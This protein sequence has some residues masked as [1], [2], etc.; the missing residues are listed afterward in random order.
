MPCR[1][2]PPGLE[3]RRRFLHCHLDDSRP[4]SR[5]PVHD[6]PGH[7]AAERLL[8]VDGPRHPEAREEDDHVADA[9]RPSPGR[10]GVLLARRPAPH[11]CA[12]ACLVICK[13][14]EFATTSETQKGYEEEE[15]EERNSPHTENSRQNQKILNK[16]GFGNSFLF[17]QHTMDFE[18]EM[19][20]QKGEPKRE[21][22]TCTQAQ[23]IRE[24]ANRTRTGKKSIKAL[25]PLRPPAPFPAAFPGFLRPEATACP[26]NRSHHSTSSRDRHY[27]YPCSPSLQSA[28]GRARHKARRTQ[29]VNET[30][31]SNWSYP[32]NVGSG[33]PIINI[34]NRSATWRNVRRSGILFAQKRKGVIFWWIGG[35]LCRRKN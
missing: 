32:L 26:R 34:G 31:R 20:R 15:E 7:A 3:R 19:F 17:C 35:K 9:P 10:P 6:A 11:A 2:P 22:V 27:H 28:R 13:H 29:P 23:P 30:E 16:R 25:S 4:E 18:R 24:N 1:R 8:E 5:Q 21:T 14:E 12:A 33:G